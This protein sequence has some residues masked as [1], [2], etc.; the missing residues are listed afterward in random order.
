MLYSWP[1]EGTFLKY[2]GDGER[3]HASIPYLEYFLER[4]AEQEGFDKIHLVAHSMGNQALTQ[5]LVNLAK[6]HQNNP[7]FGQVILAAPD[8]D[9][10]TF[11]EEIAPVI[12]QTAEN[13]TLYASAKDK[14]LLLSKKINKGSRAGQAGKH[15]VVV[16]HIETVD[17]SDIDTDFLGHR[18]IANTWLLI[19]DLHVLINRGLPAPQRA[20][21]REKKQKWFYWRF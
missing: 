1:S 6:K 7:L 4:L 15:L 18:Y 9:S 10:K 20:L 8:I 21:I 16:D 17:A 11:I 14:A 5:S 19:N 12:H 2:W 13:V 3:N